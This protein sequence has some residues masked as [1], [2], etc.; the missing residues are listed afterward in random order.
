MQAMHDPGSKVFLGY[1][2]QSM[3]ILDLLILGLIRKLMPRANRGEKTNGNRHDDKISKPKS[4]AFLTRC[5]ASYD[6]NSDGSED[7]PNVWPPK[8]TLLGL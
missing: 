6:I 7:S 4:K 3:L 8:E 5:K 2:G 1:Y